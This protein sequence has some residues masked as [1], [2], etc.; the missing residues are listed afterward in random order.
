MGRIQ[1]KS[2][3]QAE[4]IVASIS[5][6][7][8]DHGYA[9]TVREIRDGCGISSNSVTAYHL[10]ILQGMRK[11]QWAPGRARTLRVVQ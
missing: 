6:Y 3:E 11:V 8:A 2:R 9:P 5:G 10:G 4:A 7:W 1:R